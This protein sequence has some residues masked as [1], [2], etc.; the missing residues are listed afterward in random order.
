[1]VVLMALV[2]VILILGVYV[3]IGSLWFRIFEK[4]GYRR[5]W[6]IVMLLPIANIIALIALAFGQWPHQKAPRHAKKQS[7]SSPLPVPV[8]VCII[9]IGALPLVGIASAVTV[10]YYLRTRALAHEQRAQ[11]TVEQI[12]EAIETYR[13]LHEEYPYSEYDLTEVSPPY[14]A[15]SYH[16]QQ[17]EGYYY[18]LDFWPDGFK[19]LAEP[20]ECGVSARKVYTLTTG[21][22]IRESECP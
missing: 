5:I 14:L 22:V 13:A 20:V 16:E 3:F 17:V 15:R 4:M 10:P 7:Q 2:P 11:E 18:T 21:G 9:L 1:M 6:G 8:M 19:V 12:H